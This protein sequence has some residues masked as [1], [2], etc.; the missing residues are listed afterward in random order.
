MNP[1]GDPIAAESPPIEV[2][3]LVGLVYVALWARKRFCP[4]RQQTRVES[5][6][7]PPTAVY[8]STPPIQKEHHH[9]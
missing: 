2:T 4:L 3:V 8:S 5:A 1:A 7:Q 6:T 9:G